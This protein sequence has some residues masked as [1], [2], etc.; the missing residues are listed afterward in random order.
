MEKLLQQMHFK[1][2]SNKH[3]HWEFGKDFTFTEITNFGLHRYYAIQAKAGHISGAVNP[4]AYTKL[5][6]GKKIKVT[7]LEEIF[8]QLDDAFAVLPYRYKETS[9]L[10]FISTFIIAISGELTENAQEKMY[11]KLQRAGRL[12]M[13]FVWDR[14][15]I[16]QLIRTHWLNDGK[17]LQP[18]QWSLTNDLLTFKD[19]A[20]D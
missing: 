14:K 1:D 4:Q 20:T 17:A 10:R 16:E 8:A 18:D 11:W 19:K 15:K 2:I 9:E 5:P 13:V 12:G 6:D 7:P 3:G